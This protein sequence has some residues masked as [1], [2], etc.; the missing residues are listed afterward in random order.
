M[1]YGETYARVVKF[2]SVPVMLATVAVNDLE[3]H[4][5]DVVTE[6]LHGGTDN[7]TY[8]DVP[9]GFKD[10][11]RSD[12]VCKLRKALYGLKASTATNGMR[13]SMHFFIG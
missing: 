3:L 7:D 5:M 9:A 6:F 8:M 11:S 12:L 4:Q 2:I 10:P 13:K 1:D